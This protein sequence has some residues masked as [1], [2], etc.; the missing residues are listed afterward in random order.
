MKQVIRNEQDAR[1]YLG[2]DAL[3]SLASVMIDREGETFLRFP[4]PCYRCDGTGFGPWFQDGGRCYE[5]GGVNTQKRTRTTSLKKHA[6]GEK[7]KAT[8][9]AKKVTDR[10]VEKT[11]NAADGAAFL[12]ERPELAAA[13]LVESPLLADLAARLAKWGSISDKQV[14]LAIKVAGE[15]ELR[16]VEVK[17]TAPA[18]RVEITGEVVSCKWR[19]SAYGGAW[20][21]TVKVVTEAGAFRVW[22][23]VPAALETAAIEL[24][25]ELRADARRA[26]AY[27]TVQ[28]NLSDAL[29]GRSITFTGTVE[30]SDEADF[31]FFKRPSKAALLA[32]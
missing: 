24:L 14:A 7:R 23:S 25:D 11:R 32:A 8:A 20:K 27:S 29:R 31:G 26:D 30:P 21:M 3:A 13:L 16:E 9:A 5:C 2:T 28:F 22:G 19:D 4:A 10:E 15:Q 17:G 18:G 6:Q 1:T 12:A